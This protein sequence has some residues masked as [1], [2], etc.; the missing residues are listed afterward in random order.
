[1]E[2]KIIWHLAAIEKSLLKKGVLPTEFIGIPLPKIKVSWRQNKQGKGKTKAE[3][4][5]SLNKLVQFQENGCLVCTVETAEGSWGRL[6]P[7]WESLHQTGMSLWALGRSTLMVVMFNGRPTDSNCTTMQQLHHVN[8]VH[9][10]M[11]SSTILS[12]VITIHKQVKIE[13]EDGSKPPHKFT[14]FCREVMWPTSPAVDGPPVPLFDA[15]IP[16]VSG[17]QNGSATVTY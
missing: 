14:N 10:Y 16:I 1:V 11:I 13:M 15:I 5:L 3:K 6:G 8:V 7:L 9:A 12:H 4:D 17:Q 2:G